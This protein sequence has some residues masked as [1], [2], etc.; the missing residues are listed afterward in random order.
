[1]QFKDISTDQKTL[2]RLKENEQRVFF[3][4]NRGGEITFELVGAGA[5]AHIFSF[6]IG[7]NTQTEK[8]IVLQKHLA[9]NTVSSAL[10]KN[11]LF[12]TSAFTYEGL[13]HIAQSGKGSDASQECR[14]LLLSPRAQMFTKPAL[15]ILADD[16]KCR[17]AAA[18][19]PINQEALFFAMARGLSA[20]Q[21][22][23]LI[24]S[25]FLRSALEALNILVPS[26]DRGKMLALLLKAAL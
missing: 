10:I 17:H 5:E 13:I 14:T 8:L 26:Q 20:S 2:Y 3:M 7:K 16:V 22:Q 25:G 9:P 4:L 12:D 21:A 24:I 6:F 19:S 23:E 18:V 11:V 1:M 15:E